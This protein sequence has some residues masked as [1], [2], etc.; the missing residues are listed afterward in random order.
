VTFAELPKPIVS[1]E[2]VV[3][4]A[5]WLVLMDARGRTAYDHGHALG[6][7][8]ADLD[9]R[10][11]APAPHP[12]RGGRHPLPDIAG[13]C[14]WLAG[15]GVGPNSRIVVYD[16]QGGANAAA[17]FWWTMRALGHAEVSVVD[18]GFQELVS[19][20]IAT[21]KHERGP[22]LVPPYPADRWLLPTADVD[23]VDR[24]RTD[25]TACVIDARAAPR[26]RG[27]TE[28]IDPVAG[29]I[30]GAVNVPY[31]DNLDASGRFKSPSELRAMYE[32]ALAGVSPSRVIAQCGS[33]VTACHTLLAMEIAGL[34][35]AALYVGSWSEWCRQPRPRAP[36]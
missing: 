22:A 1:A 7:A 24:L 18:G 5:L 30:P 11:A 12:E 29:H 8:H 19:A 10:L 20:G 17:R 4:N 32:A 13:L 25:P 6:A 9:T 2:W 14:A 31:A 36:G 16:D 15:R 27:E 3:H 34:T 28:P 21:E 33:G 23:D 35:G 26:F